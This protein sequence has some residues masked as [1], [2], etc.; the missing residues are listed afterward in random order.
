M[1][2][3]LKDM[4]ESLQVPQ[5]RHAVLVH[6][7]VV[8]SMLAVVLALVAAVLRRNQTL[9]WLAAIAFAVVLGSA[10]LATNSGELAEGAMGE[11]SQRAH[12]LAHE[13]EELAEKV[14]MFALGGLVLG[15][16][17]FVAKPKWLGHAGA[18]GAVLVG[19]AG[20]GQVANT[21]HHGGKL[22]YRLGVGT[23]NP[24]Q[25]EKPVTDSMLEAIGDPRARFFLTDVRPVLR[26]RCM[27]CHSGD[28]P[29][30]NL[31]LTSIDGFLKRDPAH[32]Q[33]VLPGAPDDGKMMKVIDWARGYDVKMPPGDREPLAPEQIAAIEQW[34][35]DG[36]VWMD[37]PQQ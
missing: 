3:E 27:G 6:L 10:F 7:P 25:D 30:H 16:L 28:E 8:V 31:D 18:W 29:A 11:V 15:G 21:A 17:A 37:P 19:I 2:H 14:W 33:V 34:I 4:L 20:A 35:R 32:G 12:R 13:H 1:L 5:T 26:D 23:P 22:V 9:R 24:V 36:A